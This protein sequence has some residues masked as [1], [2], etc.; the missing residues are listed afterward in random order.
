[1][2]GRSPKVGPKPDAVNAGP[3]PDARSEPDVG[4]EPNAVNAGSKPDGGPKPKSRLKPNAGP[5]PNS[6]AEAR[7]SGSALGPQLALPW[8]KGEDRGWS[9]REGRHDSPV[10][11]GGWPGWTASGHST[12]RHG[13]VKTAGGLPSKVG[14]TRLSCGVGGRDG[15]PLVIAR[16][17]MERGEDRGWFTLEGWHNSPVVRGG[18]PGWT[19]SGHSTSRHGE[20]KTAGG[21]PSKVG[22]TRLSCGVGGRDGRPLHVSPWRGE[23]RGWFTLEG[24]HNSPVVRGGWPGWT[25]SGHSTSR[26][27]EVKTAGGLP[28][29]VGTTRLS[30]GVGG[31]DGQPLVIARLV[32]E[33]V[34]L[35]KPLTRDGASRFKGINSLK[36]NEDLLG[37]DLVAEPTRSVPLLG[38]SD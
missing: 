26:H 3:E 33:S 12:S 37:A 28:S 16:L 15:R 2:P 35:G 6:G 32:M 19:A 17:A 7:C 13:E 22:T 21:L 36:S 5:K 30:C 14:T 29:K 11:R 8:R 4:P 34:P 9:T 23:D 25:A 10:M 38:T 27:G 31:R 24:W 1:M 18:W 20:V